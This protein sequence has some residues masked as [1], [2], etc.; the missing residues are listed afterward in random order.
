MIILNLK[1]DI[2][3]HLN[4]SSGSEPFKSLDTLQLAT[5]YFLFFIF[6]YYMIFS[7]QSKHISKLICNLINIYKKILIHP[8][9][10]KFIY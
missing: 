2:Y 5:S 8:F 6:L 7:N 4:G 3:G 1:Y 9:N 10:L